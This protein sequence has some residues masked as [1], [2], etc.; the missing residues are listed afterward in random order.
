MEKNKKVN[1]QLTTLPADCARIKSVE[2]RKMFC[3]NCGKEI[4]DSASFCANCGARVGGKTEETESEQ[5]SVNNSFAS[6]S[7]SYG[8][9]TLTSQK[10]DKYNPLCI[11]GFCTALVSIF[12][13]GWL[14]V[15]AAF[16]LCIVG[17]KQVQESGE[18]GKNLAVAGIVIEAVQLG[19]FLVLLLIAGGA[20]VFGIGGLLSSGI[21]E[22]IF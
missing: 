18:K 5:P 6:S 11:G 15:V 8:G 1:L 13:G 3:G 20:A 12:W 21:L 9:Q 16:V 19:I 22:E 10:Q 17:K 2:D 7:S 14:L 4:D